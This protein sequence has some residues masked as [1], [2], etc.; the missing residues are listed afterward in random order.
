MVLEPAS[1]SH[2]T[3]DGDDDGS[4]NIDDGEFEDDDGELDDEEDEE[5]ESPRSRKRS[6]TQKRGVRFGDKG[7]RLANAYLVSVKCRR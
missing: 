1:G 7:D 3:V 2:V 6:Q 5:D 4:I